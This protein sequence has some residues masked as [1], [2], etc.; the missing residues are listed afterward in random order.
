MSEATERCLRACE[1][2][3]E[4]MEEDIREIGYCLSGDIEDG[5]VEVIK[6]EKKKAEEI[7]KNCYYYNYF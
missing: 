5:Y 6:E 4:V 1:S 3:I 2:L 7:R